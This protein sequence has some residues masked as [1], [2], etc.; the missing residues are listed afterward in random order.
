MTTELERA[1]TIIR[2]ALADLAQY[3][4]DEIAEKLRAEGMLWCDPEHRATSCPIHHWLEARLIA[5]RLGWFAA[6]MI[7][8]PT[9]VSL[10]APAPAPMYQ[11]TVGNSPSV[12][13]FIEQYDR[14]DYRHLEA[15]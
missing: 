15:R 1:V 13:R 6:N 4:P 14:G 7:V 5:Y 11:T 2:E 12:Q 9:Y 3:D 10:P 8:V